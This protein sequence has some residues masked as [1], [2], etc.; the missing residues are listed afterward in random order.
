MTTDTTD[1]PA[2]PDTVQE[3]VLA[4]LDRERQVAQVQ[5]EY[6]QAEADDW[7]RKVLAW[8][9]AREFMASRIGRP[10]KEVR[11]E[12]EAEVARCEAA[13]ADAQKRARAAEEHQRDLLGHVRCLREALDEAKAQ[14]EAS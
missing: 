6:H 11:A 8:E 1:T 3:S 2:A 12:A 7:Q 9:A 13:L 5:L 10:W 4:D 14:E